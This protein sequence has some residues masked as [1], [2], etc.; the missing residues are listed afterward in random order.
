MKLE[1]CARL[2]EIYMSKL[3]NKCNMLLDEI[4]FHKSEIKNNLRGAC[5]NTEQKCPFTLFK[6]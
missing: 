1:K 6:K 3:C 4:N 5:K 2:K